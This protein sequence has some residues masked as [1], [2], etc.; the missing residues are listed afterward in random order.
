MYEM[1]RNIYARKGCEARKREILQ[2]CKMFVY[3]FGCD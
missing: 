1:R 3:A 2:M